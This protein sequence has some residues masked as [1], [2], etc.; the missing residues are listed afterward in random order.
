MQSMKREINE[1]TEGVIWKQLLAFF[2]PVLLGSLFQQLYN[3]AKRIDR[4]ARNDIF[5]SCFRNYTKI[6]MI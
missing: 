4:S 5:N 3:H 2:F 1:I 6:S